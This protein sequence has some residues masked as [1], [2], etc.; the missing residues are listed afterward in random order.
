MH[1]KGIGMDAYLMQIDGFEKAEL[2][3]LRK[4]YAKS[5]KDIFKRVLKYLDKV[6]SAK[7][8]GVDYG[9]KKTQKDMPY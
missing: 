4:K 2:N 7:G 8:G 6:W 9:L 1:I 3:I 5:N